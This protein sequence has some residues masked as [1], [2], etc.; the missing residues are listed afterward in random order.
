MLTGRIERSFVRRL[1]ELPAETR[2]L[3]LVAAAEPV[4]DPVLLW[5]AA[6]QLGIEPGAVDDAEREGLVA[7][8][9]RVTFRHPLVRSAAYG[10][11]AAL[12]R[13]AVHLALAQATDRDADPDRRA[14]HLAAA[15]GEPDETVAAELQHSASR[16][17]A[18]GGL[19]TAAAFLRR[20]V[21]LTPDP[22]RRTERAL[23]A[24]LA[25]FQA[26]AI[27]TA[28]QL[29]GAVEAGPLDEF[30]RAQADLLRGYVATVS[31]DG[32]D[33]APLLLRA[34]RR[35]EPFDLDLARRAYLAAWGAAV[36][37]G[38][39]G[40]AEHIVVEICRAVRG[41]PPPP[42]ARIHSTC[43]STVSPC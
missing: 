39:H 24:A 3:L 18:R 38:R 30:Q 13:R 20:A 41:L 1:E 5:R 28:L 34:A 21:A 43:C 12:E 33:A 11:A 4:G 42:A 23:A 15:A 26:G 8:G 2:R 29:V 19:A 31:R 9:E 32:N 16:A 37:A 40:G 6:E 22:T 36:V 35:L 17:Q 10:S 14:W 7:V 27:D 25:S